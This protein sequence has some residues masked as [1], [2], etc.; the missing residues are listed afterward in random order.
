MDCVFTLCIVRVYSPLGVESAILISALGR[1]VSVGLDGSEVEDCGVV[2]L[3]KIGHLS[4]PFERVLRR[5]GRWVS[6]VYCWI[7]IRLLVSVRDIEQK[8]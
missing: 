4:M 5:M 6:P 8:N 3:Q 7:S 1:M 2:E